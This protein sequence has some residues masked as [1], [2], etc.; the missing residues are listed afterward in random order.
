MSNAHIRYAVKCGTTGYLSGRRTA[1]F[2]TVCDI[3]PFHQARLYARRCDAQRVCEG[4]GE[5]PEADTVV[6]VRVK[7]A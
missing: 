1:R 5:G 6:E 4:D 7:L 2:E 3:V